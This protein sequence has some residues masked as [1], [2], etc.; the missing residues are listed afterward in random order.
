VVEFNDLDA[1]E[2][3]LSRQDIACVIC[4]PV[5]TNIGIIY[6]DQ[7]YHEEL[8]KMTRHFG[9]LLIIDETHSIA[10]GF[11]GVTGVLNLEPDIFVLG[12]VIGSGVPAAVMGLSREIAERLLARGMMPDGVSGLGGTLSANALAIAAMK[13]TLKDIMTESACDRMINL[14][15]KLA[16]D[17]DTI[18]ETAGLPWHMIR[19]GYMLNCHRQLTPPR[20]YPESV[21]SFDIELDSLLYL[22][23]LNRGILN[24]PWYNIP[25]GEVSLPTTDEDIDLHNKVFS[26]CVNE[27]V[28]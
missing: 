7:N 14:T 23:F 6:P 3:A 18:I 8:R 16:N 9:T 15:K 1:L 22:F 25:R 2:G 17:T 11:R 10:A 24:Y 19:L 20:N 28:E 5:M 4:E 12:K 13:V 26:E 27:L 21:A